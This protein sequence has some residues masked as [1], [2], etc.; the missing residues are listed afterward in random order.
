L[1]INKWLQVRWNLVR[2][3]HHWNDGILGTFVTIQRAADISL[4]GDLILIQPG[5][6]R[7][8]VVPAV[9]GTANQPIVFRG[10]GPGV[11]LDGADC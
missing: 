8:S 10:A 1:K 11:I 6:Y 3:A 9:S 4:P 2:F 5:I 7:E